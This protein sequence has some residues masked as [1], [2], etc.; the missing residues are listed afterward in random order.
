MTIT[1]NDIEYNVGDAVEID[2]IYGYGNTDYTFPSFKG[3]IIH[4]DV[5]RVGILDIMHGIF[6]F[7]IADLGRANLR[8][9]Q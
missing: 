2:N 5:E 8:K 3:R 7:Q 1:V 4:I 9:S 6:D